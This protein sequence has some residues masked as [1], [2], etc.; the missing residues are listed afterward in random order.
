MFY[1]LPLRWM[2]ALART[3][4]QSAKTSLAVQEPERVWEFAPSVGLETLALSPA[5]PES[6]DA[7]DD[8]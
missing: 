3:S 5:K 7:G 6:F 8:E 4:L 2:R 1:A